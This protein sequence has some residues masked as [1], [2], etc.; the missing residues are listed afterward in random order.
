M[1]VGEPS[2]TP[3]SPD[4]LLRATFSASPTCSRSTHPPARPSS[5]LPPLPPCCVAP[6]AALL[7]SLQPIQHS[8][9]HLLQ[10]CH[11][12]PK[13]RGLILAVR[14]CLT[15]VVLARGSKKYLT[16]WIVGP[17]S[18]KLWGSKLVA[19]LVFFLYGRSSIAKNYAGCI[20]GHSRL[21]LGTTLFNVLL[22]KHNTC[23]CPLS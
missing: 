20:W 1:E 3:S 23:L 11:D 4:A 18:H 21:S 15:T 6:I 10:L 22:H 14:Q 5:T 16:H 13:L 7:S 19:F 2:A 8:S 17:T 9:A 12:P